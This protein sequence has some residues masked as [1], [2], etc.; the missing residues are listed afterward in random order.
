VLPAVRAQFDPFVD[1]DERD[2]AD[3]D[4]IGKEWVDQRLGC[5]VAGEKVDQPI[6][7]E[8]VVHRWVGGR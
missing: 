8:Q 4:A 7:V 2:D 3:G 6:R 5:R 1:L